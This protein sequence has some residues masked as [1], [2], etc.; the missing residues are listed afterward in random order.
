MLAQ[1][2]QMLGQ[3]LGQILGK[4]LGQILGKMLG[5]MLGIFVVCNMLDQICTYSNLSI[6]GQ[7][8]AYAWP[9]LGHNLAWSHMLAI[10]E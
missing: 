8:L 10:L 9:M 2:G 5:Q 1:L 7:C 3:I 6:L 4:I